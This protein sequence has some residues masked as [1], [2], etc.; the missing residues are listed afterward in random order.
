MLPQGFGADRPP[1][2]HRAEFGEL[3]IRAGGAAEQRQQRGLEGSAGWPWAGEDGVDAGDRGGDARPRGDGPGGADEGLG[4]P[5][6]LHG[7]VGAGGVR[8]PVDD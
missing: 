5:K 1:G 6:D 2:V 4:R 8:E 3:R 7:E